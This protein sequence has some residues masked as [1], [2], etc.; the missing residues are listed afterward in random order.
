MEVF[1]HTN[2]HSVCRWLRLLCCVTQF[3]WVHAHSHQTCY[4]LTAARILLGIYLLS[5]I[6]Q[7]FFSTEV[8]T[9]ETN[10]HV[11]EVHVVSL[12]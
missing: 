10:V 3:P 1:N 2:P 9:N 12:S 6:C 5:P 11:H 4:L 7:F 8:S